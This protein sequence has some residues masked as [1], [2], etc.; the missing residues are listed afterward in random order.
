MAGEEEKWLRFDVTT[1]SCNLRGKSTLSSFGTVSEG[2]L[3]LPTHLNTFSTASL[4][5]GKTELD[6]C[7]QGK[8]DLIGGITTLA[9]G[10]CGCITVSWQHP[11][12][13]ALWF[14]L[15]R[16]CLLSVVASQGKTVLLQPLVL[17]G[18]FCRAEREIPSWRQQSALNTPARD[19]APLR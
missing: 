13:F 6:V 1:K 2:V 11:V 9:S 15:A 4:N 17:H 7:H 19:T 12:T 8:Y 3:F 14:A 16:G 10:S 18:I 5:I